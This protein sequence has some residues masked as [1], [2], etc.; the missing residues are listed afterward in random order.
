MTLEIFIYILLSTLKFDNSIFLFF[1][2][3]ITLSQLDL[4]TLTALLIILADVSAI[5]NS[6]S[7]FIHFKFQL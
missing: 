6:V 2:S 7:P 4:T 3:I 1:I 5:S